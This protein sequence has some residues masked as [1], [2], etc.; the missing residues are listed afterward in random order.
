[1][2]NKENNKIDKQ[3]KDKRHRVQKEMPDINL[4]AA[5][6]YSSNTSSNK[7]KPELTLTQIYTSY[8]AKPH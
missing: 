3:A 6:P 8:K 2:Y 7:T 4:N 5:W 1:L